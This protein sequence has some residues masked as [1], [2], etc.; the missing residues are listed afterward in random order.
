MDP[1]ND[2]GRKDDRQKQLVKLGVCPSDGEAAYATTPDPD[3]E[4]DSPF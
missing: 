3:K 2:L 1:Q 4:R